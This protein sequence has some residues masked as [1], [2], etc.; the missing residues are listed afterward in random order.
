MVSPFKPALLRKFLPKLAASPFG[1]RVSTPLHF[2]GQT[3]VLQ[4]P[5]S[6]AAYMVGMSFVHTPKTFRPHCR[7]FRDIV[8]LLLFKHAKAV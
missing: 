3:N 8:L 5:K 4:Q 6:G 1:L 7:Y 2:A